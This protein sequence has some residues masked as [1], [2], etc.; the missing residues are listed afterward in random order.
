[1]EKITSAISEGKTPQELAQMGLQGA[2][3]PKVLK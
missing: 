3:E 2:I 1:M